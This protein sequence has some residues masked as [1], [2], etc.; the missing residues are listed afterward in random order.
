MTQTFDTVA[1]DKLLKELKREWQQGEHLAVFGPTGVGKTTFLA[2]VL[3]IRKHVVVLVT[4]KR[5]KTI[6]NDFAG[7][8]RISEWPPKRIWHTHVLLWPDIEGMTI[9]EAYDKQRSTFQRALNKIFD[10]ENWC[11]V[12]DEQHYICQSLQLMP[13]NTMFQHQGR[14]MGFTIVNGAQRPAWV[15][16]VTFSGST[17]IILWKNT[18]P[19]D[20]KRLSSIGGVDKRDLEANLRTLSKH[21][22]VYVNTRKG[23]SIR[24]QVER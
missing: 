22:F 2:Q 24:S 12:F 20:M 19:E 10:S 14:A 3:P 1:W 7:Y 15:P 6:S 23:T 17:H 11:L 13:E 9:R 5:D 18:H 4:K 8:E 16:L 21:E